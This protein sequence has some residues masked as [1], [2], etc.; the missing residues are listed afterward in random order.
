MPDH[1]SVAI[2]RPDSRGEVDDVA[3]DGDLFRM[4]RMDRKHWWLCIYRGDQRVA[5]DLFYDKRRRTIIAQVTEDD[6]G[7]ID[8]REAQP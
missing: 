4:E 7:C 5:F 3:I 2:I 6:L 1:E 8:D